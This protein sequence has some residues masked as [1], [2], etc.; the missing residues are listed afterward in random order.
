MGGGFREWVTNSSEEAA[1]NP[2]VRLPFRVRPN[3]PRGVQTTSWVSEVGAGFFIELEPL[4]ER[5]PQGHQLVLQDR[6]L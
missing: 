2:G 6:A 1:T 5:R 3:K 4:V